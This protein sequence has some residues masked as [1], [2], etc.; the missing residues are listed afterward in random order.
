MD[1]VW[2][3]PLLEGAMEEAGLEEVD[4]YVSRRH[5][6]TTQFITTRPIMDL[7]L[8]AERSPGSRATNRLWEKDVLNV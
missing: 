5:N 7:Y 8:A 4:T 3:Y 6:T 1:D 2:V